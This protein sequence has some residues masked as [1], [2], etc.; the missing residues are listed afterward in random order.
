MA[1]M[2]LCASSLLGC[3]TD[4]HSQWV[5]EGED[6]WNR[7][8]SSAMLDMAQGQFDAGALDQADKTV[9]EAATIDSANP[10]LHLMAGRIALERG[11]LERA[12][13]LFELSSKLLA[14]LEPA[15]RPI[16]AEAYYYQ[17]VVLQRWQQ[18][19]AALDAYQSAYEFE[20]EKPA[21]M[22]AV[23][24]TLVALDRIQ[25]AIELLEEK[26][27]YFGLNPGLRAM[28]GHLYG[29]QG[30]ENL[31]VVNFRQA[32]MLDP[33]NLRLVEELA[34]AQFAAGHHA[35][36]AK[37]LHR[38]IAQ[39][40]Y[41]HRS[42]LHRSLAQVESAH[43]RLDAARDIYIKLT[44]QDPSHTN[45]W[46][47]LGELCW[48][49]D[50]LGGALIAANRAMNLAPNRHESYLLAGL[51]AQKRGDIEDA[52]NLFDRAATHAPEND[53]I[54]FILRGISLEKTDRRAAAIEAYTEALRRNPE[55]LRVQKLLA[56][57]ETP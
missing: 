1:A 28:L 10:Q 49:L 3:M 5:G 7:L 23:A 56:H 26:K 19:N 31:A 48:K 52:I 29:M 4:N 16:L 30:E 41:K 21:R 34:L 8:R 36:A 57:I 47:H 6:R 2:A 46:L 44:R 11:E 13:R 22:L 12:F 45:D 35:D 24:E 18:H 43:G 55:D 14:E 37:G 50:D 51:I 33:E 38:L 25:D 42:D 53:A 54:P 27:N 9:N 39:P 20:P 17:G 32:V 15:P 40:E